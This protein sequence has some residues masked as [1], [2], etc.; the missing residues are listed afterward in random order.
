[1]GGGVG[2]PVPEPPAGGEP[3]GTDVSGVGAVGVAKGLG[4]VCVCGGLSC[5]SRSQPET[6]P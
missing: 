6:R 4:G 1:M 5:E 3:A 2:G